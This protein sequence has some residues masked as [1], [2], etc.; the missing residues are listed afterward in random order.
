MDGYSSLGSS[1]PAIDTT[2]LNPSVADAAGAII[3]DTTDLS[4]FYAAL[5]GGRL[6]PR[7]QLTEMETTVPT[8][9]LGPIFAGSRYGL[10][11]LW[12]PLS[13]GGGY[14]GHSGD[15]IGYSTRDGFTASG[16]RVVVMAETGDGTSGT[17]QAMETLVDHELCGA[18]H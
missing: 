4:R 8:T 17:E 2:A 10:G 15:I 6:L 16:Q 12:M 3:S 14:F 1:A 13:C 18:T 5:A 7:A 9:G 11:L